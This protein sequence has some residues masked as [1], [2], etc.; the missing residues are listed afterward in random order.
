[1]VHGNRQIEG[2]DFDETYAPTVTYAIVRLGLMLAAFF[3]WTI[4]GMGVSSAYVHANLHELI[5]IN[6]PH[7]LATAMAILQG[8]VLQLHQ[9][10]YG[11]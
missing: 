3:G 9:A 4:H 6:P 10:L 7:G 11:L 5:F 2:I 8:S 1:M